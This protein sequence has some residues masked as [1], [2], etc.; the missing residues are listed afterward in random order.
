V[1]PSTKAKQRQVIADL[2]RQ[3]EDMRDSL[4]TLHNQLRNRR[5]GRGRTVSAPVTPAKIQ[6]VRRLRRLHPG[7]SQQEIAYHANI[8]IGRVSEILRGKRR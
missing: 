5:G 6:E 3:F 8:N 2:I 1:I 4:V 7:W